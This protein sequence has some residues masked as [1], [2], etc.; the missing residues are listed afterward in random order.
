L[1]LQAV[2]IAKLERPSS[3]WRS[4]LSSQLSK[5]LPEG[6]ISGGKNMKH[7]RTAALAATILAGSAALAIAQSSSTIGTGGSSAG[8]GGTSSTV[9]TGGSSAG[10]SGP[11]STGSTGPGAGG[12]GKS[13]DAASRT[14]SPPAHGLDKKKD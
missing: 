5:A 10:S 3:P 4:L 9:G 8:S 1:S 2:S 12:P 7:L 14:G 13:E 11:S 6:R